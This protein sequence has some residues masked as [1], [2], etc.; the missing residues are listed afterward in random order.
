MKIDKISIRNYRGIKEFNY[1]PQKKVTVLHGPNGAGKSTVLSSIQYALCGSRQS[2]IKSDE[3][4]M[5][6]TVEA[7]GTSF[8][9]AINKGKNLLGLNGKI[10]SNKIY[11][12][13]VSQVTGTE[14]EDLRFVSSSDIL[15]NIEP[16]SFGKLLLK[17]IP[18]KIDLSRL[19]GYCGELT[20]EEE[21]ILEYLIKKTADI[22]IDD[23]IA[24]AGN[25]AALRREAKRNV[26]DMKQQIKLFSADAPT[27]TVKEVEDELL[28]IAKCEREQD[29]YSALLR[30]YE[31]GVKNKEKIE[32]C[33]KKA[34]EDILNIGDVEY[35]QAKVDELTGKINDLIKKMSDEQ[36]NLAAFLKNVEDVKTII[37]NLDTSVCPIHK[38]IVCSTDKSPLKE[39]LLENMKENEKA[40]EHCKQNQK[41]YSDT[42]EGLQKEKTALLNLRDKYT[43][44]KTI[45]SQLERFKTELKGTKFPEK[46]DFKEIVDYSGKKAALKAEKLRIESYGSFVNMSERIRAGEVKVR[47][48]DRLAKACCNGGPVVTAIMNDYLDFFNDA[49]KAYCKVIDPDMDIIFYAGGG[50][51]FNVKMGDGRGYIPFADLSSGEKVLVSFAIAGMLNGLVGLGIASIDNIDALDM[52]GVDAVI[53]MLDNDSLTESYDHIFLS[54]TEHSDTMDKLR[55][56][57]ADFVEL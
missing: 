20:A 28:E 40:A 39:K 27:R 15:G 17:Y 37:D 41:E 11:S 45:E 44:K 42:L 29:I 25:A 7:D 54:T 10:V 35:D 21:S 4:A 32:N 56:L 36:V 9:R 49:C 3:E 46:P 50:V 5:Q 14:A 30:E 16:S 24:V 31:Q 6:V 51:T 38:D 23:V 26:S 53:R 48:Y 47:A 2:C 19:K 18:E 43:Q 12:E 34:E 33:I 13:K 8:A 52:D 55:T 57:D 22:D 1:E